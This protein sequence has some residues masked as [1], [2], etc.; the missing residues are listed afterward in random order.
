MSVDEESIVP[1]MTSQLNNADLALRFA[2]RNNLGGADEL[3]VQRF[4]ELFQQGKYQEAA[5][6]AA[7]TPKGTLRTAQTIQRFQTVPQQPGQTA[8]L[9]QYFGILLDHG[10]LNKYESLEL[11]RP[12]LLQNKKQ[13][14][15]KWLKEDKLECSEELGDLVK[16]HDVTL[17]LSIYLRASVPHKVVQCFAETG[18]FQKIILYAKKVDFTPDYVAILRNMMRT[19]P[20]QGADFAK[21]LIA[22]QPPLISDVGQIVDVFM[23][24][25]LVKPATA[26]LL[27][28]LKNNRPE[29]AALQTRLL[30]IN[31]LAAPQV[32]DA[33]LGNNM[34]T[35]YDRAHIAQLC[36]QAGL[37]Q[38]VRIFIGST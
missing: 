8:P 29:D 6:I 5:K 37:L 34:F 28:A 16:P 32:A 24:Q 12:V 10:K 3:F 27:E 21:M 35:H 20:N 23:E 7:R 36:E 22:E 13:L 17:A 31:L 30:E 19:N 4:N 14:L 15:E 9:L 25:N 1:Y 26:F 11:C 33:I 2:I 38:R 18:Q